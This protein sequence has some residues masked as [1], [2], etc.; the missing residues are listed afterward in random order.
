M[1]VIGYWGSVRLTDN[2]SIVTDMTYWPHDDHETNKQ[3]VLVI[4]QFAENCCLFFA[5]LCEFPDDWDIFIVHTKSE[6]SIEIENILFQY[7][8]YGS[9]WAWH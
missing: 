2:S 7:K 3:H 9:I 8:P 6:D 5:L 4:S 1:A